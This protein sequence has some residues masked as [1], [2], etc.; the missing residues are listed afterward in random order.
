MKCGLL[1]CNT[2]MNKDMKNELKKQLKNGEMIE[3]NNEQWCERMESD[4]FRGGH[5]QHSWLGF[6]IFFNG[7]CI[8]CSKGFD[9]MI[10][11]LE[12]LMDKW[13]CEF[14]HENEFD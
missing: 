10:K 14:I 7:K 12:K 11:R 4:D 2:Q 8:H 9:S 1:V 5:I 3:F 6:S 13:N